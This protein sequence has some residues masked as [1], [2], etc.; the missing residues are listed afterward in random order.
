MAVRV[1][2]ARRGFKTVDEYV[3]IYGG[4]TGDEEFSEETLTEAKI[5]CRNCQVQHKWMIT[6]VNDRDLKNN[7][8][9]CP[10]CL[11]KNID[12]AYLQTDVIPRIYIDEN[13]ENC[14]LPSFDLIRDMYDAGTLPEFYRTEAQL[15]FNGDYYGVGSNAPVGFKDQDEPL[16]GNIVNAETGQLRTWKD[17]P[18]NEVIVLNAEN[19]TDPY[20]RVPAFPE[21]KGIPHRDDFYNEAGAIKT[22]PVTGDQLTEYTVSE[23]I[24]MHS[25]VTVYA[26]RGEP[27]SYSYT[28]WNTDYAA[29]ATALGG[30]Q[31]G[32]KSAPAYTAYLVFELVLRQSQFWSWNGEPQ[33]EHPLSPEQTKAITDEYDDQYPR[34]EAEI[35]NEDVVLGT[36]VFTYAVGASTGSPTSGYT[37]PAGVYVEGGDT[38]PKLQLTEIEDFLP[39]IDA[40]LYPVY[41][42]TDYCDCINED[43]SVTLPGAPAYG[44]L[45]NDQLAIG[46]SFPPVPFK[47]SSKSYERMTD[48]QKAIVTKY[49]DLLLP[50]PVDG[51]D[52]IT[53]VDSRV[54]TIF[55]GVSLGAFIPRQANRLKPMKDCKPC[56]ISNNHIYSSML[57]IIIQVDLDAP[58]YDNSLF[59]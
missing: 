21:I 45:E 41:D 35:P 4:K 47:V 31:T 44:T 25:G 43:P 36:Y 10:S 11:N 23:I 14:H 58:I 13:H 46:I 54:G 51:K 30:G 9:I 34:N 6:D 27:G 26:R 17:Y 1:N 42:A 48:A 15:L 3:D 28:P 7:P 24:A 2:Y 33:S 38:I 19:L 22:N 55:A 8:I 57:N 20:L 52:L 56:V 5:W 40:I 32:N 59:D 12:V 53:T 16:P 29:P 18:W 37:H 39:T 49:P 50:N